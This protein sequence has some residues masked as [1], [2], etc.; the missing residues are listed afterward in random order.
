MSLIRPNL[1]AP[2]ARPVRPETRAAQN[3][4]FQAAV[5]RAQVGPASAEPVRP[6]A[7]AGRTLRDPTAEPSRHLRPG[8]LLD[9]KV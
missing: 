9:I 7:A 5:N 2:I 6:A 3:A 4:F 8:S 1:P